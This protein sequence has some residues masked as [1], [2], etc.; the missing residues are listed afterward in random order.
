M[1]LILG[2]A[3]GTC[4]ISPQLQEGKTSA[5]VAPSITLHAAGRIV[6]TCVDG[7]PPTGGYAQ[8]IGKSQEV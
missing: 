7:N 6:R 1:A 8:S 2:I 4:G 3:D 5:T